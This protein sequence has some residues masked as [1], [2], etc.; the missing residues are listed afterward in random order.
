VRS[1]L[2]RFRIVGD[3]LGGRLVRQYQKMPLAAATMRTWTTNPTTMKLVPNIQVPSAAT[4][5]AGMKPPMNA[6]SEMPADS[7][8]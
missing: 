2:T 7:P 8:A 1:R 4:K 5:T 3:G 6:A